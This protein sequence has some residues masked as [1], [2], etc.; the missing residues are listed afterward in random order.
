[1]EKEHDL[2]D[3]HPLLPGSCDS[4]PALWADAVHGLQVGRVVADDT[5]YLCAEVSDQL[6]CQD[7]ADTLHE[8][9]GQVDTL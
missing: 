7:G 3:L 2:S 8:A 1:M 9:A 6:L 4:F 5:Q